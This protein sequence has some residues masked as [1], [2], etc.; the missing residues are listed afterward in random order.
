MRRVYV[1]PC[2]YEEADKGVLTLMKD[3]GTVM[4][5][6]YHA[7]LIEDPEY[8]IMVDTGSS[9]RWRELHPKAMQESSPVHMGEHEH[10]DRILDSLG[11]STTDVNYVVNT[12]LHYDHCGNNEMFPKATFLVNEAELAHAFAPGWWEAPNYVRGLFDI[13]EL[14]YEIVRGSLEMVPGVKIIP[15]PGHSEGHQS[16]AVQLEKAG[17][18]VLAGDAVFLR[19]NLEGPVLPGLYTDAKKY[20]QSVVRVKR[21]IETQRGIMI[22]SHSREYLSSDGW[23]HMREGVE[24]FT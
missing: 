16:V 24:S 21:L 19:E 18:V 3:C 9:V 5:V 23:K 7:Y 20:A 17:L 13:P 2:G 4:K 11:F 14:K 6:P 15:T 10:L 22:M 12:H 8:T 1:L